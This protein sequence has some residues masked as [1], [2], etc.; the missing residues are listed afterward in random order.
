MV[1]GIRDA[2]AFATS[3]IPLYFEAILL[4]DFR[5]EGRLTIDSRLLGDVFFG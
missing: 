5:R 1:T 3:S 2:Y 4:S